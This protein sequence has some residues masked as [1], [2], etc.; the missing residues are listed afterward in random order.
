LRLSHGGRV[1][2]RTL[3]GLDPLPGV[4]EEKFLQQSVVRG[5]RMSVPNEQPDD[6]PSNPQDPLHYA[7]PRRFTERTEPRLAAVVGDIQATDRQAT[8]RQPVDRQA[9]DRPPLDRAARPESASR[10]ISPTALNAKLENAVFE[11]L[12]RQI[13]PEMVPEPAD[14]K[15]ERSQR[16]LIGVVI[17]VA[18]AV[19]V[20]AAIAVVFVT[21]FPSSKEKLPGASFA[22]T[23]PPQ[24]QAAETSKPALSEFR[25][26]LVAGE[27]GQAFTHEQSERLL[28]QFMQWRQ[29]AD[30]PDKP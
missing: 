28:Q 25:A 8:D 10:A 7:P 16:A 30:T 17:G 20:S 1:S 29:K 12:R 4:A 11:S 21:M 3:N 18:A 14:F 24:R 27:G 19:V 23:S 26:L 5:V 2:S 13:E 15:R 6:R 9:T 22:T